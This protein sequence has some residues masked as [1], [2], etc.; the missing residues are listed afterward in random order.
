MSDWEDEANDSPAQVN[1]R[2]SQ[3]KTLFYRVPSLFLPNYSQSVH[4]LPLL[5]K[6]LPSPTMTMPGTRVAAAAAVA[7]VALARA[8]AAAV[9][10]VVRTAPEEVAGDSAA[11]AVEEEGLGPVAAREASV[12]DAE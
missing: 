2:P 8:V 1:Y 6:S 9:D 4:S 7:S 10:L 11:L 3:R 5:S 12:E